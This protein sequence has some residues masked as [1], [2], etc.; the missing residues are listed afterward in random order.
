MKKALVPV[1]LAVCALL[2]TPSSEAGKRKNP[3]RSGDVE[4]YGG[5]CIHVD[6]SVVEDDLGR[7]E[8][9]HTTVYRRGKT[10]LNKIPGAVTGMQANILTVQAAYYE[11]GVRRYYPHG[12]E[13]DWKKNTATMI[14]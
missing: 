13:I 1:L 14:Y 6:E 7:R 12:Y 5:L 2:T 8:Y 11:N 9:D 4:Y 3:C 10:L